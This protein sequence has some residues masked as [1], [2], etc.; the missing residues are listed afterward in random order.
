MKFS[1]SKCCFI[2]LFFLQ[3]NS[4]AEETERIAK[5]RK[6]AAST[7][8]SVKLIRV[9][10]A[11]GWELGFEDLKEGLTISEEA[12]RL[13]LKYK[14]RPMEAQIYD[15]IGTF[16]HD[17]GDAERAVDFHK[18]AISLFKELPD[19]EIGLGNAY[20]NIARV[21]NS[22]GDYSKTLEYNFMALRLF[23][24]K[25][26]TEG[27]P[28]LY[29]NIGLT[30]SL[31]ENYDSAIY[32]N[33]KSLWL[34]LAAKDSVNIGRLYSQLGYIFHKKKMERQADEFLKKSI[35]ILLRNRNS[36]QLISAYASVSRM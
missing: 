29:N 21:Y 30:Y 35:A 16:Y 18:K 20:L 5:L 31:R 9:L 26:Y 3:L 8:D 22:T 34:N 36:F 6:M 19:N 7:T 17:M 10:S 13:A 4:F 25:S 24:S 28:K 23:K 2:F 33:N 15:A 14:D 12:L 27:L 32:Y 11:L 1:F